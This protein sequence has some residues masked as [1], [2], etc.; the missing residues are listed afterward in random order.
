MRNHLESSKLEKAPAPD[1]T[2]PLQMRKQEA[3]VFI[4]LLTNV[5]QMAKESPVEEFSDK[6][7]TENPEKSKPCIYPT[8]NKAQ[9]SRGEETSGIPAQPPAYGK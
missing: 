9:I 2:F 3:S 6:E 1:R 8:I 4:T 5:I 7:E